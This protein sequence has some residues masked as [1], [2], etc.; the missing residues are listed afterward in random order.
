M[1]VAM[2]RDAAIRATVLACC[3]L[4]SGCIYWMFPADA[5]F[6]VS[7]EIAPEVKG[8]C[9][10][11]MHA[12]PSQEVMSTRTVTG[13]F[14]VPFTYYAAA[15][16]KGFRFELSCANSPWVP[17]GGEARLTQPRPPIFPLGHISP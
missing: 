3:S 13:S 16:A 12:L 10:L 11:R 7:G 1:S 4:L 15:R 9:Q 17:V 14:E 8:P 2:M 5:M 6:D